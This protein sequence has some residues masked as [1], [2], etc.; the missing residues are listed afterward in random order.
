MK[1]NKARQAKAAN[2]FVEAIKTIANK[3]ENLDNLEHYLSLH[4]AEWIEKFT[5]TPD[6]IACEM[7]C[8]A[9]MTID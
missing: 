3:P 2:D 5:T 8:F 4:F 1:Y 7:K 9:E 6:E